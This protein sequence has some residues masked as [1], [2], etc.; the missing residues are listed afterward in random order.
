MNLIVLAL[1]PP[2]FLIATELGSIARRLEWI[3]RYMKSIAKGEKY[4]PY[5]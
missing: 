3:E 1:L 5:R 4:D 2:L